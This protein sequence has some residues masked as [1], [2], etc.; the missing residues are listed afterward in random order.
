MKN[1]KYIAI[2]MMLAFFS[3]CSSKIDVRNLPS[4]PPKT[5]VVVDKTDPN[6]PILTVDDETVFSANWDFGNGVFLQGKSIQGFF[7]LKGDYEYTLTAINGAGSTTV[8]GSVNV[9][10]SNPG[11]V[12]GIP[13]YAALVGNEGDGGKYWVFDQSGPGGDVSFMTADYDWDEFWW[14]PYAGEDGANLP[15]IMNE[16]KFDLEGNFNYTRYETKDTELEA[17]SFVLNLTDMTLQFVGAN[18][19]NYDDEN[20]NP[21]VVSTGVYKIKSINEYELVLWQDQGSDYGYGWTWKFKARDLSGDNPLNTLAGEE[22]EGGK[23]W[24]FNQEAPGGNVSYM[25]ANYD[26]EEFWWNPYDGGVDSPELPDFDNDIKFELDG[27]YTRFASD[28]SEIEKGTYVFNTG[29]MEITLTDAH[30]PNYNDE[31]LDSEVV[32]TNVYQ[33]KILE[34]NKLLLWQDQSVLNPDDFDYGWAWEFKTKG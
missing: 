20:L 29:N 10:D 6:Q 32:A 15:G 19:P 2:L 11:M 25:T 4:N 7:P 3:A 30:I 33:V 22:G 26:W 5:D 24:V 8:Q 14:N 1:I 18:I 28:G 9:A 27:T 31:N 17:G 23:T 13:E 21:D 12:Y 16:M 34:D